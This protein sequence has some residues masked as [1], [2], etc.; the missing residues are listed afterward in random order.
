MQSVRTLRSEFNLPPSRKIKARVKTDQTKL[1]DFL[2]AESE[3]IA[4]LIQSD[5]FTLITEGEDLSG[6]VA[7]VGRTFEVHV[8]I[9]DLIDVEK[10]KQK[11]QKNLEKNK[12][13]LISTEKK[14]SN[15]NFTSRAP[16][17]V[18]AKEKEKLEEF[19]NAI[20]KMTAYLSE[21]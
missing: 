6:S 5:D 15:E 16:E 9:R 19:R 12:K 21:L 11:L 1:G 4:A 17:D 10:E 2:N 3:L 13:M 14:L 7:A 20:E 18:I 8:Y